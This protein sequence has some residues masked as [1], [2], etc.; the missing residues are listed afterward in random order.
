MGKKHPPATVS[1]QTKSIKS[2]PFSIIGLEKVKVSLPFISN[3]FAASEAPDRDNHVSCVQS[4]L[5]RKYLF[6]FIIYCLINF[7]HKYVHKL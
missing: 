1:F 5:T 6:N 4:N 2:I 7:L 3:Y